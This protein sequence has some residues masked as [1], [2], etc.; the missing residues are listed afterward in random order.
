MEMSAAAKV[1]V[2][3]LPKA[4]LGVCGGTVVSAGKLTKALGMWRFADLIEYAD[5]EGEILH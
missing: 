3:Q 1:T 4:S 2:G 5:K